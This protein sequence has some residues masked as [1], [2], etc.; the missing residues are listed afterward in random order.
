MK[1]ADVVDMSNLPCQ[2]DGHWIVLVV[3]QEM[4][5]SP[6]IVVP[7]EGVNPATA[8]WSPGRGGQAETIESNVPWLRQQ[9]QI[10]DEPPPAVDPISY[11]RNE[12]NRSAL[13]GSDCLP[14][15]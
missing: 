13:A 4:V 1:T 6:S 2:W 12:D 5:A 3:D 15:C 9:L 10:E 11:S 7:S 14:V 8:G